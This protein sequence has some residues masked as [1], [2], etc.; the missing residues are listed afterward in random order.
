MNKYTKKSHEIEL[1]AEGGRILGGILK[2]T[3]AMAKPGISTAELNDYAEREIRIAGGRPSFQGYGDRKN[4][5][6]A[7][8]CT[9]IN[10][11]VVHGV[12]SSEDILQEGDI[13]GLDIG[14]EYKGFYTDTAVTVPVGEISQ[15]AKQI[16]QVT[17]NCLDEALNLCKPGNRIGDLG[18]AMQSIAE[19]A[20]FSV[21]RDL[22]GHGVGYA[23][24]EDPAVP[25]Y[26]K[27]GTGIELVENMV[28][29]IEPMVCEKKP[30][31][32]YDTDGWTIRT[33]DGGLAAHFEH[34]IAITQKG[35]KILTFRE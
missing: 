20:G 32:V 12:P 16:I 14:M 2:R 34:T 8:L 23:V 19:K 27:P 24:H 35:V 1:I 28:L 9:S 31:V 5:F 25:C 3:A 11:A 17:K 10:D 6:P 22:V 18:F 7:G 21:V 29:A 33:S 26:G 4:P 13:I 30:R 15:Q